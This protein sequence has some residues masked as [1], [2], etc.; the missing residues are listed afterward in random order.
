MDTSLVLALVLIGLLVF[1]GAVVTVVLV[2]QRQ[3]RRR[4]LR[5]ALANSKAGDLHHDPPDPVAQR[6]E[7]D[8]HQHREL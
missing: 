8:E 2:R 1:G 5:V 3:E 7:H 6:G 4:Q